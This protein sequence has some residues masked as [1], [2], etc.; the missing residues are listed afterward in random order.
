[1]EPEKEKLDSLTLHTEIRFAYQ[2]K[3]T[4]KW[5]LLETFISN[6]D[7]YLRLVDDFVPE[8][9]AYK[10]RNVI[11]EDLMRSTMDGER[12]AAIHFDEFEMHEI[13]VTHSMRVK[14]FDISDPIT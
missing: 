13:N 12:F 14:C 4:G 7:V 5:C 1:M 3:P 2:H 9:M 11:E 8:C 6:F 10:A